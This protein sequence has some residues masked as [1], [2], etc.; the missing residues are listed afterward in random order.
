M[1]DRDHALPLSRQAD[2]L[3]LSRGSIY[4]KAVPIPDADLELMREI[5]ILHTDYPF[6]GSRMRATPSS[7]VA[8]RLVAGTSLA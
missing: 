4:Y 7:G 1:I 6:A 8:T 3:D 5:D 2:V